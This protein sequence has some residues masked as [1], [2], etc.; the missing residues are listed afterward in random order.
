MK[1][2]KVIAV[3][4]LQNGSHQEYLFKTLS[5]AL[6]FIKQSLIRRQDVV[7]VFHSLVDEDFYY[8]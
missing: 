6:E 2:K 4:V 8:E 1:T 5:G 7:G 3:R